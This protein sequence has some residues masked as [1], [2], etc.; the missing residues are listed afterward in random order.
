[1]TKDRVEEAKNAAQSQSLDGLKEAAAAF[2]AFFLQQILQTMRKT[3]PKGGLIDLGFAGETYTGMLDEA[4]ADAE[5][6]QNAL[7]DAAFVGPLPARQ[8]ADMF[9]DAPFVS[10]KRG[11]KLA[12]LDSVLRELAEEDYAEF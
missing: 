8:A 9:G 4:L 10:A 2:E 6:A 3:V 5:F 12:A 7:L 1:M 11:P